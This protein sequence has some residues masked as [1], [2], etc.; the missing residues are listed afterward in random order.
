MNILNSEK[1]HKVKMYRTSIE[2]Y[3][4]GYKLFVTHIT[5]KGLTLLKKKIPIS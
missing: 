4:Q 3:L 2:K 1:Y 5:D